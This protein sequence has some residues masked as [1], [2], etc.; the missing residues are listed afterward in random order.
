MKRFIISPFALILLTACT[1]IQTPPTATPTTIAAALTTSTPTL[2]PWLAALP[3][4]VI[5]VKVAGDEIFGLDAQGNHIKKFD[6]D[7]NEWQ[8]VEEPITDIPAYIDAISSSDG[9]QSMVREKGFEDWD[10]LVDKLVMPYFSEE[11]A[12][13]F[14]EM[15]PFGE[16]VSVAYV[17]KVEDFGVNPTKYFGANRVKAGIAAFPGSTEAGLVL[18]G[19]W[20]GDQYVP[21]VTHMHEEGHS[22]HM[23]D[24]QRTFYN[25]QDAN[26]LT[27]LITLRIPVKYDAYISGDDNRPAGADYYKILMDSKGEPPYGFVYRDQVLQRERALTGSS[28]LFWKMVLSPEGVPHMVQGYIT[29]NWERMK[30][31]YPEYNSIWY[32]PAKSIWAMDGLGLKYPFLVPNRVAPGDMDLET[33][34]KGWD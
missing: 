17:L 15:S 34:L 25:P 6:T 29:E 20:V 33:V 26:G 18:Y 5:S 32:E 22:W 19:C 2:K 4:D 23:Y 10:E 21:I 27:G 12:L 13:W 3:E 8:D 24:P 16:A 11:K 31:K 1:S 7:K 14:A 28:E 30:T 9:P